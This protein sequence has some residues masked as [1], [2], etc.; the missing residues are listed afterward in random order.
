M[1]CCTFNEGFMSYIS[2]STRE[3]RGNDRVK[4]RGQRHGAETWGRDQGQRPGAKARGKDKGQRPGGRNQ[5]VIFCLHCLRPSLNISPC[6][7]RSHDLGAWFFIFVNIAF[8]SLKYRSPCF[9]EKQEVWCDY[10]FW[11]LVPRIVSRTNG[12]N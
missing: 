10:R 9:D 6:R 4:G 7:I 12:P 2:R 3:L 11:F 5:A 1:S 8:H